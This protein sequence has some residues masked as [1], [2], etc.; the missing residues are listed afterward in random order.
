MNILKEYIREIVKQVLHEQSSIPRL[1]TIPTATG[2]GAVPEANSARINSARVNFA[3]QAMAELNRLN[4]QFT[5]ST[6]TYGA[7]IMNQSYPIG[8]IPNFVDTIRNLNNLAKRII[9]TLEKDTNDWQDVPENVSHIDSLKPESSALRTLKDS[10]E[11]ATTGID[12][13]R[14]NDIT[15]MVRNIQQSVPEVNEALEEYAKYYQA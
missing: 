1:P 12:V 5:Q 10:T 15:D 7:Y 9:E 11:W 4:G 2:G 8:S 13:Q 3:R 14:P 6:Q